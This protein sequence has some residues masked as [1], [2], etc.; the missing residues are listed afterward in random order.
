[1]PSKKVG[2]SGGQRGLFDFDLQ[3]RALERRGGRQN[4]DFIRSTTALFGLAFLLHFSPKTQKPTQTPRVLF[5]VSK[6]RV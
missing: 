1:V 3:R 5:C 4:R 6:P 2:A